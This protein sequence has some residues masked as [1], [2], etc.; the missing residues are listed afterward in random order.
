MVGGDPPIIMPGKIFQEKSIA[1]ANLGIPVMALP[2]QLAPAGRAE[3]PGL[4]LPIVSGG[5]FL[6]L[7]WTYVSGT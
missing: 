2:L 3:C 5:T 6:S 7:E 1:L 4:Q